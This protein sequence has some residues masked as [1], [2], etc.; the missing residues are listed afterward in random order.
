[1]QWTT[2]EHA[3]NAKYLSPQRRL[4]HKAAASGAIDFLCRGSSKIVEIERILR[5]ALADDGPAQGYDYPPNDEGWQ[6]IREPIKKS[7]V[8]FCSRAGIAVLLALYADRQWSRDW[9]IHLLTAAVKPS[10]RQ[11]V[12]DTALKPVKLADPS[13]KPSI[14]YGVMT[15]CGEGVNGMQKASYSASVDLPFSEALRAQVEGRVLRYGQVHNSTHYQLISEHAAERIIDAQHC[16]KLLLASGKRRR[17][18]LRGRSP[19]RR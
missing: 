7:V 11:E 6:G 17:A 18:A 2:A 4:K 8:L 19:C 13:T 1:M 10:A 14:L 3:N 16:R 5:Q 12:I 9:N 15:I